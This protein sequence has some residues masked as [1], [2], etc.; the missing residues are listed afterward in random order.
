MMIARISY[1][2]LLV[3]L[4]G[5]AHTPATPLAPVGQ[6]YPA[7]E[8]RQVAAFGGPPLFFGAAFAIGEKAY[9]GTGYGLNTAF[10]RYDPAV[11]S[12]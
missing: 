7:W 3:V 10:W 4:M 1:A 11:F 12:P 6:N 9:I 2:S 5:G 8:W